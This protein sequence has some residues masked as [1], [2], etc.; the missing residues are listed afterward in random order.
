MC[1]TG[2]PGCLSLPLCNT[3]KQPAEQPV[4]LKKQVQSWGVAPNTPS[5]CDEVPVCWR[6]GAYKSLLLD[7]AFVQEDD[8]EEDAED[9]DNSE[10]SER[11][12]IEGSEASGEFSDDG[13]P[14]ENGE[15]SS[16]DSQ[17]PSLEGS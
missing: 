9:P 12:D 14:A 3:S 1:C 11:E 8:A 4:T 6:G 10:R 2:H 17:A 15:S 13:E 7:R 16:D 5:L